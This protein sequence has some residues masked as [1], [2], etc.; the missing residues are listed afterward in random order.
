MNS[1]GIGSSIEF[2]F[3]LKGKSFL[4]SSEPYAPIAKTIHLAVALVTFYSYCEWDFH[5]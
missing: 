1:A 3:N 4:P 2:P 5:V